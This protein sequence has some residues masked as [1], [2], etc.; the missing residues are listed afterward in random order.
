VVIVSTAFVVIENVA[1]FV[2]RQWEGE[3]QLLLFEHPN[4]GVQIPAGT[5]EQE[6]SL[7][8]AVLREAAEETGLRG[9]SILCYLGCAGRE[10][11]EGQR[12]MARSTTVYARPDVTSF[13]WAHL[14]RGIPVVFTGRS[15]DGF[16]QVTYEEPDRMP[17]PQYIT[18]C[19]TGWVPD[20][21]LADTQRR[22]FSLLA[23]DEQS[24]E[25]WT[26]FSDNHAFTLFWAALTDL[27]EIVHPQDEWLE[28]LRKEQTF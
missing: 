28:F 16:M 8:Q 2:T 19:I 27:P 12:V 14:R 26:V 11:L 23:F 6:E 22:R 10:L 1:A 3:R 20:E 7:E 13:G 25:R 4:A 9:L 15:V 5:I 21:A 24:D 17:D 18:M